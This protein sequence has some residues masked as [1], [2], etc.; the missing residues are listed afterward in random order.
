MRRNDKERTGQLV[1]RRD[2][3]SLWGAGLLIAASAPRAMTL[4]RPQAVLPDGIGTL[5]DYAGPLPE[6]WLGKKRPLSAEEQTAKEIL[7]AVPHGP[8]PYD[9]AE[10]F[11]K[12][13]EGGPNQQW[14]PYMNGWPERW[15]PLIVQFFRATNTE[16]EGDETP[17]CAAFVN[18][19]YLRAGYPAPTRSASSGSFRCFGSESVPPRRG[20]IVVFRQADSTDRCAG[21]GHVGFFVADRGLT[22]EVLGGN[23]IEGHDRSHAISSMDLSKTGSLVLHSYRRGVT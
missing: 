11:R 15:N 22:V 1:K 8:R 12:I 3:L 2:L 5:P 9:V 4:D 14:R 17:W 23:Q 21:H 13:A 7:A 19:C 10:F 16:P 6:G 20:D 18:W